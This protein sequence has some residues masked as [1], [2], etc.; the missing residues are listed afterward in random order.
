MSWKNWSNTSRSSRTSHTITIVG[1]DF[2][3]FINLPSLSQSKHLLGITVK[4]TA[5]YLDTKEKWTKK[6]VVREW[7]ICVGR[8]V[9]KARDTSCKRS[10]CS[11]E[12]SKWF[13]L[14]N[15]DG[16]LLKGSSTALFPLLFI[17]NKLQKTVPANLTVLSPFAHKENENTC[18]IFVLNSSE[19]KNKYMCN[20]ESQ[21]SI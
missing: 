20:S 6:F 11:D 3:Y 2:R 10:Y 8:M 14:D 1:S 15:M 16:L 4:F 21:K 9:W 19:L 7:I 17:Y 18:C 5:R 12:T 13:S